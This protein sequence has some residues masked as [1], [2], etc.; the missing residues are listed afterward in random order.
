MGTEETDTGRLFVDC[1]CEEW[2]GE[3]RFSK[4]E[5]NSLRV[6]EVSRLESSELCWR[7][8]RTT[9]ER[10]T[11]KERTKRERKEKSVP[12]SGVEGSFEK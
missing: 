8:N 6:K 3:V 11:E 7:S 10:Q 2:C 12:E 5:Q 4:E 9:T 1:D